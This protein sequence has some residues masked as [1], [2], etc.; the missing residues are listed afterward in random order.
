MWR[1]S[2]SEVT[3]HSITGGCGRETTVPGQEANIAFTAAPPFSPANGAA[4]R[5]TT[6]SVVV[7]SSGRGRGLLDPQP[8]QLGLGA[9]Q[10]PSGG[11]QGAARAHGVEIGLWRTASVRRFSSDFGFTGADV[12]R[13][14]QK[15]AG[16]WNGRPK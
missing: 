16:Y 10:L 2:C 5:I 15:T 3:G 1:P 6:R 7:A 12:G 4:A 11:S 13:R 14:G 9:H 8:V